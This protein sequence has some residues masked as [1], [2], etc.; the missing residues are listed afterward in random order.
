M[1]I[2]F[3]ETGYNT[4][5]HI[6]TGTGKDR[7]TMAEQ[8]HLDV[9]HQGIDVWNQWRQE[10]HS[11]QPDFSSV[12]FKGAQL[13]RV[14]L[15]GARLN[16][17][18]FSG[19]DLRE[20]L[21]IRADLSEAILSRTNLVRADLQGANLRAA[22][23]SHANLS[24]AILSDAILSDADLSGAILTGAEVTGTNF[25]G[26]DFSDADLSGI[27]FSRANIKGARLGKAY[28]SR[29]SDTSLTDNYHEALRAHT[30]PQQKQQSK[31]RIGIEAEDLDERAHEDWAND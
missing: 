25:S 18:D 19:A 14:N 7:K 30:Q 6:E 13:G 10:H 8:Y 9:L 24:D 29:R 20:S 17:A 4:L 3:E 12:D 2:D 1:F 28:F 16:G 21:L 31:Q 27:D 11:I 22:I 15:A 23:L 26:V 5:C